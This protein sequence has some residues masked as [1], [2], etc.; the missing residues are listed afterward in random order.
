[1]SGNRTFK[2]ETWNEPPPGSTL[3]FAKGSRRF[4]GAGRIGVLGSLLIHSLVLQSVLLGARAHKTHRPEVQGPGASLI[5]SD[6]DPAESLILID[7]PVAT[8][9]SKPLVEDLASAGSAPKNLKVTMISPDPLPYIEIHKDATENDPAGEAAVDSGDRA[10]RAALF[11]RY[12]GQIDA[13]IERAWRRP[14]SPVQPEF[15]TSEETRA[16]QSV[17]ATPDA[18][19]F[20][21]QVRIL[22]D[23]GGRVEEVQLLACNGTAAWQHSLVVAILAASP[24]PAPP[25]PTVFTHAITLTFV[26]YPYGPGSPNDDYET[27][28]SPD[29]ASNALT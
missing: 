3:R 5:K 4:R 9:T 29:H 28:T 12:T 14:R 21:C 13:R 11:G 25:S 24:L 16:P 19:P 15:A 6:T 2:I 22:Q 10:A 26:G 1:M 23:G 17:K 8:L 20:R 7:L 18:D 27:E